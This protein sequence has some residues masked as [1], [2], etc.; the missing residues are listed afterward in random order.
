[1][2]GRACPLE[3][4]T[5]NL[6]AVKDILTDLGTQIPRIKV[7]PSERIELSSQDCVLSIILATCYIS[8]RVC[9]IVP[10]QTPSHTNS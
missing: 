8:L 9:F 6:N 7:R 2:Y 3:N 5:E 10:L 4:G 1:M